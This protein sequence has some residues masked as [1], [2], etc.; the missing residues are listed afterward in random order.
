MLSRK[1]ECYFTIVGL[2][3]RSFVRAV[4]LFLVLFIRSRSVQSLSPV[5]FSVRS[6]SLIAG[7]V[8]TQSG[9]Y[10][11]RDHALSISS[12]RI[13][14]TLRD[15]RNIHDVRLAQSH[16]VR[17]LFLSRPRPVQSL[18]LTISRSHFLLSLDFIISI[19]YVTIYTA[20]S[21]PYKV[22]TGSMHLPVT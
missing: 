13:S 7:R 14:R 3:H 22:Q 6:R 4:R 11:S 5:S 17:F 18:P 21:V 10:R 16:F 1:K 9:F 20:T 15:F 2:T 19:V 8:S 12:G